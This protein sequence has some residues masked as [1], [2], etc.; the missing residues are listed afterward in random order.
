MPRDNSA[1]LR[2]LPVCLNQTYGVF[3]KQH[4]PERTA[5]PQSRC[6]N[7]IHSCIGAFLRNPRDVDGQRDYETSRTSHLTSTETIYMPYRGGWWY[8]STAC[9]E[10]V[11][12][13]QLSRRLTRT[14]LIWRKRQIHFLNHCFTTKRDQF[15]T[16]NR[17]LISEFIDIFSL[18]KIWPTRRQRCTD[19]ALADYRRQIFGRLSE[20]YRLFISGRI[21]VQ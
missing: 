13:Q 20:D 11:L 7:A 15:V 1:S 5:E 2:A 21:F 12:A 19:N 8:A 18:T 16:H 14:G 10:T 6:W 4:A 3:R 9:S 17:C